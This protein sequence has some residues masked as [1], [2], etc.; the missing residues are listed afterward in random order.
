VVITGLFASTFGHLQVGAS[1]PD[2]LNVIRTN[3]I[4]AITSKVK[5]AFSTL[6]NAF[7]VRSY[8]FATASV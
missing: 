5:A 1:R 8:A 4:D 6:A 7:S 3:Q 2:C